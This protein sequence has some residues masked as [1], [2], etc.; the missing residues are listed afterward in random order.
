MLREPMDA[1]H[2]QSV[3]R[4]KYSVLFVK[5]HLFNLQISRVLI[6]EMIDIEY[7]KSLDRRRPCLE[8]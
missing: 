6:V 1:Q 2:G 3:N 5:S 4:L 7:N 8:D